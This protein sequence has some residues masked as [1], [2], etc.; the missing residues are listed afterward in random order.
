MF[1]T[2]T[3]T[4]VGNVVAEPKVNGPVDSPD[5]VTFRVVANRRQRDPETGEWKQIDEFGMNVVCWRRLARGVANVVHVGDPVLVQGRLSERKYVSKDG[6]T[7]WH[8]EVTADFVGHDLSQGYG[9]R[10]NRFRQIDNVQ[11]SGNDGRGDSAGELGADAAADPSVPEQATGDA[12]RTAES[13]LVAA[14]APF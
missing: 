4:L 14:A 10:F 9:S 5:R 3:L 8:T 7:R 13:E 12:D 11:G 6:E 1:D 2:A